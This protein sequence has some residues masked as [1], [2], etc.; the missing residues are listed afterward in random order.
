MIPAPLPSPLAACPSLLAPLSLL[1]AIAVSLFWQ[2]AT[3]AQSEDLSID[4]AQLAEKFERLELL[5]MRIAELVEAENPDRATQL[6]QAIATSREMALAD[7]FDAIVKLLEQESY[8][9]A[10]GN[11]S[12]LADSL[13]T[14][15][16]LL[17]ADPREARL[18]A[19]RRRLREAIKQVGRLIRE[20]RALRS[21]S[22]D[23]ENP[24][25]A[26]E[27]QESLA[28]QAEQVQQALGQA[29]QQ[30]SQAPSDQK[31]NA[32]QR[33]GERLSK[34]RS[35]MQKA[36]Q[37]MEQGKSAPSQQSQTEAQRELEQA[38]EELEEALR[39]TR[40]EEIMRTL[41]R[42]ADRLRR[43]LGEQTEINRLTIEV[44]E[45]HGDQAS[46][47]KRSAA[48]G[49]ATREDEAVDVAGRALRL[50]EDDGRS[51]AFVEVLEQV[52]E[53]MITVSDRL[54]K[55]STASLTQSIEQDIVEA[56][57]EAIAALDQQLSEMENKQASPSQGQ[58]GGGAQQEPPLVDKLAELRMVRSLQKRILSRTKR[59]GQMADAGELTE[60]EL[61]ESLRELARR[62]RRAMEAA[63]SMA[64]GE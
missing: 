50:L 33:A 1:L 39:Q 48:A 61:S 10:H 38:R 52:R 4:Q 19:E 20:Q 6:R 60:A 5:A 21:E 23:L 55:G 11:Q 56:L 25:D 13:D 46:P 40:E 24:A 47:Q 30:E 45:K 16:T 41:T 36:A 34:A 31:P 2:S 15:L 64:E 7:R 62:Q 17:L 37:Q 57:T 51:V 18:E 35:S 3:M 28:D 26:K 53:D 29:P 12:E 54:N 42:L 49:L 9:A 44:Q 14:L 59:F 32:K 8:A 63:A 22:L 27:K 43:L 58:S